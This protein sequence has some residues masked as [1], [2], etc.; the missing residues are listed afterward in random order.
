MFFQVT[1][2]ERGLAWPLALQLLPDLA[3]ASVEISDAW[4]FGPGKCCVSSSDSVF[5]DE[6]AEDGH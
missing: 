3:V 6:L 4:P 2:C 5:G 1:A